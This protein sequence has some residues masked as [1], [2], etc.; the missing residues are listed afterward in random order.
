[1]NDISP[2][3]R[4]PDSLVCVATNY[5]IAVEKAEQRRRHARAAP[6]EPRTNPRRAVK[7]RWRRERN[8]GESL[9]AWLKRVA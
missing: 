4:W 6:R 8:E 3:L 5:G 9:K 2:Q 1:M 7:R